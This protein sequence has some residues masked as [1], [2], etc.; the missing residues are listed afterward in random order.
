LTIWNDVPQ[1]FQGRGVNTIKM[2]RELQ[3]DILINNRTGDG[4]D[5]DTP[6]QRIGGFNME[7]S[8]ESCMTISAH[9]HW[10]WGGPEDGVK[11][12]SACLLMLIRAAG[13]D[14]NVLLNVGPTPEGLIEQCQVDRLKEIGAWLAKYGEAVYAT[15]GGPYKPTMNL[16]STRKGNTVYIHITQWPDETLTLPPLPAKIVKSSVL[17]G[18]TAEVKQTDVGVAISVPKPYRQE[19]DTILVLELDRPAMEIKPI[20]LHPLGPS[21]TTGK[22]ATASTVIGKSKKYAAAMAVDDD[23]STRWATAASTG[24]CWLEVDLGEPETFD[25]AVI[26]EACGQRVKTFE[27]QAKDGDAW[28]TFYRGKRIGDRLEVKFAPVTARVVRLNITDGQG[29]PT[30][31]EFQLFAPAGQKTVSLPDSKAKP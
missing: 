6:E 1:M 7:H 15:R 24:P 23:E 27:L 12:L 25:R 5:Y 11:P 3:P 22:R 14:G 28:K 30:I 26:L 18:G 29:G 10:A 8:W 19:I 20:A 16:A 4:G 2:V 31:S 13:G 9:G 21:L 17:T